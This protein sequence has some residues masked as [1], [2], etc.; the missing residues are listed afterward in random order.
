MK[1]ST[2]PRMTDE[3]LRAQGFNPF[4]RPEHVGDGE[5]IALVGFNRKK[6]HG[7]SKEQIV[8]EVQ[9]EG[10]H[11]FDLGVRTGS[12]DHRALHRGLGADWSTWKGSATVIHRERE[13]V[14][15]VNIA[16]ATVEFPVWFDET[17]SA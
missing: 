11:V 10:G 12:P 9:T 14:T 5:V 6:D 7:T 1:K 3:Q 8:C 4:L 15:F 13:T 2:K 16:N 17:E